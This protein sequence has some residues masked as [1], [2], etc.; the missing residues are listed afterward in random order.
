MTL[1]IIIAMLVVIGKLCITV[2]D[3][4]DEIASRRRW[5]EPD[6][7][8]RTETFCDGLME[9]IALVAEAVI[10]ALRVAFRIVNV[11]GITYRWLKILWKG[12]IAKRGA[13]RKGYILSA[14]VASVTICGN[15]WAL[16]YIGAT[17]LQETT[18]NVALVIV[19]FC[20]CIIA[21]FA[22]PIGLGSACPSWRDND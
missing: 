10:C 21:S 22:I 16:W 17:R 9:P 2:K 11:P 15:M 20:I 4:K 13:K 14:I 7:Y 3:L 6:K 18:T 19:G 8:L 5:D 12:L 1:W